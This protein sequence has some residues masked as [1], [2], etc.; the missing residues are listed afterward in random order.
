M[1]THTQ[2]VDT[3]HTTHMQSSTHLCQLQIDGK[4]V[5]VFV[6]GLH[7]TVVIQNFGQSSP[8]IVLNVRV[9]L[10]LRRNAKP[11]ETG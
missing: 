7:E 3:Q 10:L 4:R 2:S 5:A 1:H 6:L 9:M 11:R 8:V